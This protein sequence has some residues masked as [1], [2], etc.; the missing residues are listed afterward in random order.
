MYL[1]DRRQNPPNYPKD[2]Y[3]YVDTVHNR[4]T[5]E[6]YLKIGF[7]G[8]PKASLS[9]NYRMTLYEDA[10]QRFIDDTAHLPSLDEITKPKISSSNSDSTSK[11]L[12]RKSSKALEQKPSKRLEPNSM[13]ST[14][15]DEKVAIRKAIAKIEGKLQALRK[16]VAAEAKVKRA[17]I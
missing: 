4:P 8:D 6:V 7:R 3:L 14:S 2:V 9:K 1:V 15:N 13:S 16:I 12:E 11:V 17:K 10:I 5:Y